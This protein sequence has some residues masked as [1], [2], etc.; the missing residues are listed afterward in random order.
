MIQKAGK[1]FLISVLSLAFFTAFFRGAVFAETAQELQNRISQSQQ[2]LK[3][4]VEEARKIEESLLKT[5]S[6]KASLQRELALIN[7]E[8]RSLE[9]T[10]ART[11]TKIELLN[12]QITQKESEIDQ[13]NR[14]L[15]EQ[16][17]FLSSLLREVYKRE[18]WSFFE[19]LLTARSFSDLFRERDRALLLQKPILKKT[20]EIRK[21]KFDLLKNKEELRD[22]QE[23]LEKQKETIVDQKSLVLEQEKHK[24][25]ILRSTKLKESEYQKRLRATREGIARLNKQ[26]RD[27]ESKLQFILDKTKLPKKGS[28]VLGWPLPHKNPA[29]D[30]YI[31]QR[32]GKTVSS[33]VLYVS[34]SHSGTDFR[35]PI[36]TPVYAVA[37]GIVVGTGNTDADC[38]GI[39]FGKWVLIEHDVGLSTTSGHLSKIKVRKGQRVKK[40]DIIGYSGNTGHTTGPHLHLTVYAT[41]GKSGKKVVKVIRYPS[42]TCP[43]HFISR[44]SAPTRAYL[45][46]I[47]YLPKTIPSMFKHPRL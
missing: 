18:S 33:A 30:I 16:M 20:A 47:D 31:T 4:L 9:N 5:G 7:Q 10:I 12:A 2:N 6:Q 37:D 42:Y 44:P 34:G 45:N 1:I 11:K 35:A 19:N 38:P 36:G 43:G 8:R 13:K 3:K 40:G 25:T 24:N 26:I 22:K 39:S 28:E 17:N 27:Y 14:I 29:K 32:F 46:P 41:Y 23:D 15:Q 21:I